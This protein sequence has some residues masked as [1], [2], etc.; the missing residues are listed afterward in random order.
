MMRNMLL[1][2]IV[3][4]AA[5][6][7]G[8]KNFVGTSQPDGTLSV[9]GVTLDAPKTDWSKIE[10]AQFEFRPSSEGSR[11]PESSKFLEVKA[12][13]D[14]DDN[15]VAVPTGDDA[16]AQAKAKALETM[17]RFYELMDQGTAGNYLVKFPLKQDGLVE[18]I[19]VQ[20]TNTEGDEFSGLLSNEPAYITSHKM[21]DR[22]TFP[23]NSISDWMIKGDTYIYGGYSM[24]ALLKNLP[25]DQSA[26]LTAMLRD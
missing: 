18:N 8:Y 3:A 21:G 2:A 13:I 6:T 12:A 20:L 10:Q 25:E 15:V 19:W 26:A 5:G 14:S 4:V 16:I 24:R 22:V 7:I 23:K 9:N 1:V 11:I 17:P